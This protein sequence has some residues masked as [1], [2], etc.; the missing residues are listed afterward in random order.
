MLEAGSNDPWEK[1]QERIYRIIV[2]TPVF[3]TFG[4]ITMLSI[5]YIAF[6][7]LPNIKGDF[8]SIGI[9]DFWANSGERDNDKQLALIYLGVF[10]FCFINLISAILLT[11]FTNPGNIPQG[12]EWDIPE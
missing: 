11:I 1:T 7:L 8:S 9:N 2:L 3:I 12:T 4:F 6:F 5:F 10:C